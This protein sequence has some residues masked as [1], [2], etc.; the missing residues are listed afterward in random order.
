MIGLG[1]TVNNAGNG[2]VSDGRQAFGYTL[3][4][5]KRHGRQSDISDMFFA[6][7]TG[8]NCN[9]E[10]I[11]MKR[12]NEFYGVVKILGVNRGLQTAIN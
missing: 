9:D 10:R 5:A 1:K 4:R 12:I 8:I 2:Y 11:F 6:A 7:Q 3:S